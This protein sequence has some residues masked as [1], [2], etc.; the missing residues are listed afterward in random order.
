[1]FHRSSKSIVVLVR[2]GTMETEHPSGKSGPIMQY[3]HVAFPIWGKVLW[4]KNLPFTSPVGRYLMNGG[5]G[6]AWLGLAWGSIDERQPSTCSCFRNFFYEF[7][8]DYDG[9]AKLRFCLP[10]I[11]LEPTY[12]WTP[13]HFKV[14]GIRR[15]CI[16]WLYY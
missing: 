6:L 15:K 13:F 4:S 7:H 3:T 12:A 14:S 8:I 10:R 2:P 16:I 11:P 5:N 9:V 1:M